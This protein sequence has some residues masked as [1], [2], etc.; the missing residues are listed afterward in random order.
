MK[1]STRLVVGFAIVVGL[2]IPGA[3]FSLYT[4]HQIHEKFEVLKGD[5]VPGVIAM[6]EMDAATGEAHRH[7]MEYLAHP[8]E[9]EENEEA[10]SIL[11]KLENAGLAHLEYEKHIGQKERG[12]AAELLTRIRAFSSALLGVFELSK[13]GASS[14][15]LL[16]AERE[17][18]HPAA[19]ALSKQLKKQKTVH[20]EELADAKEEVHQAYVTGIGFIVTATICAVLAAIVAAVAVTRSITKPLRVLQE[21]ARQIAIGDLDYRLR[22]DRKDEIGQLGRDFDQMTEDL[23]KILTSKEALEEANQQL[24]SE[25]AGREQ[26]EEAVRENE[27][28]LRITL[29]SIGDGVIATDT[30]RRVTRLNRVAEELTGWTLQ[31][32]C[33]RPLEEVFSIINEETRAPAKDPVARVLAVGRVQGLANHTVLVAKDG[34]ERAIADSAAPIH[35]ASDRITG[36]VLVFRDVTEQRQK[37]KEKEQLLHDLSERVKELQ[38]MYGVARSIRQREA[39]EEILLDVVALI[40]AGWHY[41][42]ITRGRI[43]FDG[44][45]YVSDPFDETQWKQSSDIVVNGVSRGVVEVYYLEQRPHLDEGPFMTEERSLIDSLAR[46]LGEAIDRKQAEDESRRFNRQAVGRE[47]R[48]IEL[49]REVNEMARKAGAAPPYDLAFAESGKGGTDDE[50]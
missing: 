38:C 6:S 12:Q 40:P 9:E 48:M 8:A 41:P 28:Q 35:D 32:A 20:M 5:I 3:V 2:I 17:T 13:Q 21:G 4:Y 1:I 36:V 37:Q 19:T 43:V 24:T 49:K 15:E 18:L 25:I 34:T 31:E 22:M 23:S 42:Q 27:S 50:G 7:L 44:A 26:A 47:E 46:T 45:E 33:G 14:D 16:K 29:A 10:Q 11:K 30:Q 39:I